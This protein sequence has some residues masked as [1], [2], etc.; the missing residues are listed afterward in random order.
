MEAELAIG[1]DGESLVCRDYT[2][3]PATEYRIFTLSLL[4][5]RPSRA[6]RQ[7]KLLL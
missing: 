7:R 5:E 1:T 4:A 6:D 3:T 2:G